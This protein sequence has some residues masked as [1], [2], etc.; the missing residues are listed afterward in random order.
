MDGM[1]PFDADELLIQSEIEVGQSL[2]GEKT[3]PQ[4]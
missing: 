2:I 3:V 1:D 4:Q